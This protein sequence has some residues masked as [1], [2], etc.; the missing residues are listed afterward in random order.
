MPSVPLQVTGDN[1]TSLA[2][3]DFNLDG[4][5]ELV[6]GSE[7]YDLRVFRGDE[8]LGEI[9]EVDV[10]IGRWDSDSL[11]R[12]AMLMTRILNVIHVVQVLCFDNKMFR[13]LA[14]LLQSLQN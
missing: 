5:M 8:L 7:D 4:N 1:V 2:F 14:V 13:P 10:S 12:E 11:P 3:V 9:S 6:V